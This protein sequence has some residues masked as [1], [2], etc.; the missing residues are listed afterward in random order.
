VAAGLA[1]EELLEEVLLEEVL[2]ELDDVEEL[3]VI[4][5]APYL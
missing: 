5:A 4:A 2:E 1:D 3:V